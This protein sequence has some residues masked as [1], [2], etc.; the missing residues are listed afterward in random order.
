MKW[1]IARDPSIHRK[2]KIVA[3]CGPA[4][5]EPEIL[6]QL[7]K[8]GVNVFRLNFSHGSHEEHLENLIRIRAAS[9]AVDIP[10]AVLQDLSGPKIR[11]SPVK[12]NYATIEDNAA[13]FIRKSENSESTN[14]DVY[15]EGLDPL[16]ILKPGN[17]V[18]FADGIIELI[19]E[20][21]TTEYARCKVIKGG[22]LRSRVGIAF[23]DSQLN[24]PATTDKDLVDLT[25]G[26]KHEVDFVAVSFVQSGKDI[27]RVEDFIAEKGGD[28]RIIAKIETRTAIENIQ[29]ILDLSDGIMV[30]RGDLGL[31][32][33]IERLPLIQKE[34]IE[35][36]NYLGKP[37]IVATQMLH[38]M[39]TSTR[40]T[41]AE[42]IDCA[43]AV[44]AGADAV[45]LSEETAIGQNPVAAVSFLDKIAKEAETD[46]TFDNYKLRLQ[47]SDRATIPDAI[48]Y[49]AAAAAFKVK[50]RA[51]VACTQT[52]FTARLVAKYRPQQPLYAATTSEKA[53]RRMC[54]YWGVHAILTGES[55]THEEELTRALTKVQIEENLP[56]DSMAVITGGLNVGTPGS[57]SVVEVRPMQ[58]K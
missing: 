47:D 51:I 46:F 20:E 6:E 22:R 36:A 55:A 32:V 16:D 54:L 2:T 45:M 14:T 9:K 37:V 44:M 11:I 15:V 12:D 57:S 24:L 53:L 17:T 23:P 13:L 56:N 40:P 25:W 39:V 30:A 27:Q 38:S 31:E 26:L 19:T 8:T 18:L 4:S 10:V 50:A 28:A 58:F 7:I 1:Q 3:T 29:D 41:R 42:V 49:A 33:P 52:G 34:L 5:R 35:A 21:V 43:N 48:A